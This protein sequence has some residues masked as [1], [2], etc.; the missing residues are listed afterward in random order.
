[1][2]QPPLNMFARNYRNQQRMVGGLVIGL[3]L[4][5]M[6][7]RNERAMFFVAPAP[8]AQVFAAI[9]PPIGY[10]PVDAFGDGSS[11][12][13]LAR[14]PFARQTGSGGT[15]F[16]APQGPGGAGGPS[17]QNVIPSGEGAPSAVPAA[18]DSAPGGLRTP[19]GPLLGG[20]SPAA[21]LDQTGGGGSSSS[22]GGAGDG[23]VPVGPVPE[24]ATW[25][26]LIAG[27]LIAGVALR[28][29]RGVS[30]DLGA[31]TRT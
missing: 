31:T 17:E 4:M 2:A 7:P 1:M 28:R 8:G 22:S 27:F 5:A 14:D 18:F 11:V 10:L 19:Q 26:M 20:S 25:T 24:P 16:G 12:R 15:P 9:V 3:L 30:S 23:G 21:P 29:R 13:R 6:A